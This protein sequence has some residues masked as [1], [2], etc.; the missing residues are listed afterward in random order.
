MAVNRG[1]GYLRAARQVHRGQLQRNILP[2]IEVYF[3]PLPRNLHTQ[4]ACRPLASALAS[5]SARTSGMHFAQG[6]TAPQLTS[7]TLPT[8]MSPSAAEYLRMMH[9]GETL[10]HKSWGMH[11]QSSGS[12]KGACSGVVRGWLHTA[13]GVA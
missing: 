8:T 5:H 6:C 7:A 9:A 4:N 2:R 1:L 12:G 11:R 13:A 10:A 3:P